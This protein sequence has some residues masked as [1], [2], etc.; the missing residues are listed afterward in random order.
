[1]NL[2]SKA[3]VDLNFTDRFIEPEQTDGTF[4][5][6]KAKCVPRRHSPGS[7]KKRIV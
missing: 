5:H 1:M 6:K 4:S 7:G 3:L 2:A